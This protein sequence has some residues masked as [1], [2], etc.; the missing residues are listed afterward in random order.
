MC[1]VETGLYC[2]FFPTLACTCAPNGGMDKKRFYDAKCVRYRR[3]KKGP[4]WSAVP[5]SVQVYESCCPNILYPCWIFMFLSSSYY[6]IRTV[7]IS[8]VITDLSVSPY[9]SANFAFVF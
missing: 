1:D 6:Q 7:K 4:D 3:S 5:I 8:S 2:R 9:N